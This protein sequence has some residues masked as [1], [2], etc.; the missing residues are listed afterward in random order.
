MTD[1][2]YTIPELLSLEQAEKGHP[3][4]RELAGEVLKPVQPVCTGR[5]DAKCDGCPN[6]LA[7]APVT[8]PLPVVAEQ[9]AKKLTSSDVTDKLLL[10]AVESIA[11]NRRYGWKT[12][13]IYDATSAEKAVCALAALGKVKV[14]P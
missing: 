3:L 14:Q 5:V 8:D 11:P 13:W 2:A 12:W 10:S 7:H 4:I 9:L 6:L 1:I